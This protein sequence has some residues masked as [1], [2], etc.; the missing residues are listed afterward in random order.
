[1]DYVC[2]F[3]AF[4]RMG[5]KWNTSCSLVHVMCQYL[6]ESRYKRNYFAICDEFMAPLYEILYNKPCPRIT[7]EETDVLVHL[8]TRYLMDTYTHIMVYRA[9]TPPH[10]LP[11][12]VPNKLVLA[13]ISYQTILCGFNSFLV[14]GIVK[15][16]FIPYNFSI[17]HYRFTNYVHARSEASLMMEFRWFG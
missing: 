4:P 15:R 14:K 7:K 10:L 2:A 12:C 11:K 8:S 5:W 16:L 9:T 6:W 17:V 1:M 3:N 13:E